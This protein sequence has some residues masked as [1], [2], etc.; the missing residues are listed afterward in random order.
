MK[1]AAISKN[2]VELLLLIQT[3]IRH[4]Y[5]LSFS[6]EGTLRQGIQNHPLFKRSWLERE[7]SGSRCL[8]M[9]LLFYYFSARSNV[10]PLKNLQ[11]P[12]LGN[13][14]TFFQHV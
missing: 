10:F 3:F 1:E 13:L 6:V 7:H 8:E 12:H 2:L 14:E 11:H 9:F 5:K 4:K